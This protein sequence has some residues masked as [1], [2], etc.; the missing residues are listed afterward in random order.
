MSAIFT[1]ALL[2]FM[3]EQKKIGKVAIVASALYS[4]AFV[5]EKND[6]LNRLVSTCSN[7]RPYLFKMT[8]N[9]NWFTSPWKTKYLDWP[10]L[11]LSLFPLVYTGSLW[12]EI[13]IVD[14]RFL[15]IW[16]TLY[17]YSGHLTY[18]NLF[19][20]FTHPDLTLFFNN[21]SNLTNV[22]DFQLLLILLYVKQGRS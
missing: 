4:Q 14:P 1:L 3:D 22:S 21:I 2:F 20:N 10:L 9:S 15:T 18:F 6:T 19:C 8:R 5:L 11:H 13:A 7:K 17:R 16:R 12:P